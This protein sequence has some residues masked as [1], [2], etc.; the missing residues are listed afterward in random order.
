MFLVLST[1]CI[2]LGATFLTEN[3]IHP[4]SECMSVSVVILPI[5]KNKVLKFSAQ[6]LLMSS[7][8]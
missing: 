6:T 4:L 1:A 5:K 7:S 3:W 2:Q 8:S